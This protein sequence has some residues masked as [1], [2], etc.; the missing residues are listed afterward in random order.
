VIPAAI[1]DQ[2]TVFESVEAD[3]RSTSAP[4]KAGELGRR[5]IIEPCEL[6]DGASDSQ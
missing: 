3:T 2:A 1:D 6:Q 4:R 5:P